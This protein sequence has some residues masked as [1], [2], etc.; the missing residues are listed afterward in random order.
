[1]KK[2]I[3]LLMA[4]M[5]L[6]GCTSK[7]V[8][9]KEGDKPYVTVYAEPTADLSGMEDILGLQDIPTIEGYGSFVNVL[10]AAV[11]DGRAN[12]NLSP[13]SVYLAIAMAAEGARG[14]TQAELLALLGE[15]SIESL[16]QNA[17][18]MLKVLSAKGRTGELVLANSIWM[19]MQ[20]KNITFHEA[21]LKILAD[22]YGAEADTVPF[23]QEEAV[24]RIVAWITDK[25]RGKI[26][27]SDD[28]M[29]FDAETLAVLINTIYLKD[30][31]QTPFEEGMTVQG[32][33][34]GINGQQM[35]VNYM[36]RKDD[37]AEIVQGDGYL[38]Y[39]LYLGDVG[40]MV[41]VLPDEGVALDS[42]LGNRDKIDD[43]L[44]GGTAKRAD[45]S[46]MLPKFTFQDRTDL[47]D[48]LM[49][50]G[51]WTCFTT[52]A[53]FSG[54][55]NMSARISRILQESRIGVDE[56]GVEAAAYTMIALAKGG[57]SMD[58]LEQVDFHL[59]RPFLYAIESRDG[60][61]LF[62]GTVVE[63]DKA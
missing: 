55:T 6:G 35:N 5:L 39:S 27:V 41:F 21:Y 49:D 48:I 40:R 18:N 28:A 12:K 53:D 45:V 10:S 32:S 58:P 26:Q 23:G 59:T 19:G 24:Q 7:A 4:M 56:K 13:I 51:V 14:D 54:M 46:V 61:V 36:C 63:P 25:T 38:R 31:W 60:T 42:L 16:R 34:Y 2:M 17:E 50:L 15:S 44:H 47:E 43:L 57:I 30:S 29:Q 8:G 22:S 37:E 11:I 33:F 20:D 1:M 3:C 52:G 9:S 62:I